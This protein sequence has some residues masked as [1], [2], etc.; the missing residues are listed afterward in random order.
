[1]LQCPSPQGFSWHF[2]AATASTV[3]KATAEFQAEG[4]RRGFRWRSRR[5]RV[6]GHWPT[7][8]APRLLRLPVGATPGV[9]EAW[10][11]CGVEPVSGGGLAGDA[12]HQTVTETR[13]GGHVDRAGRGGSRATAPHRDPVPSAATTPGT[14]T[15]EGHADLDLPFF[16]LNRREG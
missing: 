2:R 14:Q 5:A 15:E 3:V 9:L 13:G 11:R 6:R 16:F 7:G 8:P 10:V 1:M 4:N 12:G